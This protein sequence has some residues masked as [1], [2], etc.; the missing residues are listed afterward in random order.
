MAVPAHVMDAFRQVCLS[1]HEVAHAPL[2]L[3]LLL[4]LEEFQR[5]PPFRALYVRA[6]EIVA[7][8]LPQMDER[9]GGAPLSIVE[10]DNQDG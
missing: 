4:S 10:N 9:D 3:D 8:G 5:R 1:H 7:D 6:R 2:N